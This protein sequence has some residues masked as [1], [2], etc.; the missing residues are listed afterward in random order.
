MPN[1]QQ[2]NPLDPF[3]N[4]ATSLLTPF[5]FLFTPLYLIGFLFLIL[6]C[7][8]EKI[9][10]SFLYRFVFLSSWMFHMV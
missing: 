5:L 10:G 3:I 6:R 2:S 9:S 7:G 1:K 8:F 4:A